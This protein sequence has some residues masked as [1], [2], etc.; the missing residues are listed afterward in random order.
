VKSGKLVPVQFSSRHY[1]FKRSKWMFGKAS[2]EDIALLLKR[3]AY[4]Q[5]RLAGGAVWVADPTEVLYVETSAEHL[6]DLA[7]KLETQG[8]IKLEEERATSTPLLMEQ[9]PN[10]E[11]DMHAALEELEKKHAFERG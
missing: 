2:D 8:L 1:D 11:A 4:W 7:R 3:K 9:A 10:F 5:T 6:L